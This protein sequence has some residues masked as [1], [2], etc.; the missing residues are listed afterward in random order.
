[1]V[2]PETCLSDADIQA[3]LPGSYAICTDYVAKY[4]NVLDT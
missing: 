1:M 4:T 2:V 3:R